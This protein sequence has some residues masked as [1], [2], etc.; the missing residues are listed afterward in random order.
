MA[1]LISILIIFLP[2]SL[3]AKKDHSAHESI[4]GVKFTRP[5]K[6]L[7]TLPEDQERKKFV[8]HL[9][10]S[11]F[12]NFRSRY[13]SRQYPNSLGPVWQPAG[14]IELYGLGLNV[15]ANFVLNNEPNQG[16]FNEV[17]L[18][19]YYNLK[20]GDFTI[21]PYVSGFLYPNG[22]PASLDYSDEPDMEVSI[23]L[24]YDFGL[25]NVFAL[26]RN[27]VIGSPG[28]L[29]GHIGVGYDQPFRSGIAL[30][31]S[32]LLSIAN[33]KFLSGKMGT[34]VGSNID[35]VAFKLGAKWKPWR[36]LAFNPHVNLAVH[37]MPEVRRAIRQNPNIKTYIVWGGLDLAYSF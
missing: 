27:N 10:L 7:I 20:I 16:E 15:W 34:P 35:T 25:V 30:Q 9:K 23:A 5:S 3:A 24:K 1:I 13:V 14:T 12:S 37:V 11:F 19:L 33:D 18:T 21:H 6:Y 22:D 29:Y 26:S 28:S 4:S 32:F 17:D 8:H 2:S 36:S 31:T